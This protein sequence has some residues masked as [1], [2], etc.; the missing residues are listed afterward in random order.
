[1]RAGLL[2]LVCCPACGN[3]LQLVQGE[4]AHGEIW[5]GQLAC[6]ACNEQ[7]AIRQGLPHLFVDDAEWAPKA[8]EAQ[9]WV[10]LH[11]NMGIYEQVED[12]VDLQ[13]PYYPEEP[14]IGVARSFDRALEILGL[15]GDEVVLDLGAGRGWA[16]KEFAK[17]GCRVVALDV[18]ADDQVGL[19]RAK[20]IMTHH[21]TFFER[22]IGDGENLP[23]LANK[24]DLVFCS[25]T[26]HHTSDLP[27]F[28]KNIGR[29]IRPGGRLCAIHEPCI[30]IL[31]DEAEILAR[32]ATDELELGINENRP[33]ILAYR[34]AFTTA[35]LA[36]EAAFPAVSYEMDEETLAR[37]AQDLGAV[38]GRFV[39][40]DP[41]R[42][43]WRRYN[44][45][46]NRVA[47]QQ[48]G[49]AL[50][51]EGEGFPAGRKRLAYQALMWVSGEVFLLGRKQI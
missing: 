8:V 41:V 7:F 45:W 38:R 28:V 43:F 50:G 33:S 17:R 11:Q 35:G 12:A 44:Y 31:E 20:A 51:D 9:G 4:E 23:F 39:F 3:E 49:I 16:A 47:V 18:V 40:S 46:K 2:E 36:V 14:W 15:T 37:W 25:A 6:M 34:S 24:F 42:S 21:A 5:T 32:D 1:M 29:V 27:L 10:T 19:G 13:I 30:S 48:K 26:L 22:V